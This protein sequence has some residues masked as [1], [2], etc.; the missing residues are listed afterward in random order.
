HVELAP[1]DAT[2]GW[3][4]G[5]AGAAPLTGDFVLGYDNG[6]RGR[7]ALRPLTF[8]EGGQ[9]V[10]FSGMDLE[11]AVGAQ[12]SFVRFNGRMDS[13][14]LELLR[15][16]EPLHLRLDGLALQGD[17][18]LG[19]SGLYSGDSRLAL[20][21]MELKAA[22]RPALAMS[23]LVQTDRFTEHGERMNG[24][25]AYDIGQFS[26]GGK[27]LGSASLQL[28]L[29]DLDVAA[30]KSLGEWYKG[31]LQRLQTQPDGD[32]GMSAE[33]RARLQEG[34]DT[35][36]EG[37]PR[38]ALDKLAL[39]TAHGESRFNLRIDLAR[40]ASYEL[41]APE[42]ARQLVGKLDAQLVLA[43]PTIRDLVM[44]KA[45]LDPAAASPAL[46]EEAMQT[47]EMAGTLAST[48]QL[49]RLEGDNI[50]SSLGYADGQIT[51][52][53]QPIPAEQF[54]D[55]LQG[56]GLVAVPAGGG[57]EGY[58]GDGAE[59]GAAGEEPDAEGEAVQP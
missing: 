13:L 39:K 41:P 44:Y 34:I 38:V 18:H 6:I 56:A 14:V 35:L 24:V 33:E 40:P 30:L 46:A 51:F 22:D 26:Y 31:F 47:A 3:F 21:R 29:G 43:K 28:S 9:S 16:G 11:M 10:R 19:K 48:R 1:S 53:G 49:A 25:F 45:V 12:A 8:A 15:D 32:T 54:A 57:E 7:L 20:A 36:L 50:V 4:N 2:R 58:L 5:S 23:D 52:N 37:R 27:P 59:E 17:H 55:L 42:L